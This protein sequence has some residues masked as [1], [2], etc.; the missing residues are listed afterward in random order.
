MKENF[1]N[2]PSLSI[3]IVTLNCEGILEKCLERIEQQNYPKDLIEILAVDGGS[4]DRTLEIARS[5]GLRIINAGYPKNQEARRAIGLIEAKNEI[6]VYLDSDN[7]LPTNNWLL[8]MVEPFCDDKKIIATQTLRYGYL[9]S[10]TLINKYAALFGGKDPI[11]FYLK[12]QDRLPWLSNRWNLLGKVIQENMNY[13]TIEFDSRIPTLGCNGF[14][15]RR[16]ILLESHH[17]PD[18]F[19]HVDVLQDLLYKGY[20]RY[21][22]VK[23]SL[24]HEMSGGFFNNLKKRYKY[25]MKYYSRDFIDKRRYLTYD[26]KSFID[27]LRLLKFIFFTVTII[28][29]VYDSIRGYF[30]VKERA[31]FLHLPMCWAM[32]VIYSFAVTKQFLNPAFSKET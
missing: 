25:M 21:G 11:P 1:N 15:V 30:K 9:P 23:N 13:Y 24:I 32:L 12:K 6:L 8:E 3:I 26:A 14:L 2:L 18:C 31:W 10:D 29:P 22:I 4:V 28:I 5:H 16:K 7:F 19:A 17:S 27:N 20:R